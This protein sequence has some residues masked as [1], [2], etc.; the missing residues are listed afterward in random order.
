M[1]ERIE[2]IKQAIEHLAQVPAEHVESVPLREMYE[3]KL[4]WEGVVEMF[5]LLGHPVAPC[6]YG[7][8]M[9]TGDQARYKAVLHIPPV[10][11]AQTAVRAA[12]VAEARKQSPRNG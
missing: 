10:D 3:D 7:W 9:G 11:S 8:C 4:V 5:V 2:K 1:S 12:I 6:A